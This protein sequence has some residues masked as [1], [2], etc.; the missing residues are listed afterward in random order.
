MIWM[1]IEAAKNEYGYKDYAK[2]Y[3]IYR[4]KALWSLSL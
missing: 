3:L 1:D 2:D 4:M